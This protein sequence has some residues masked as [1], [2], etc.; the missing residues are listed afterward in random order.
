MNNHKTKY[1]PNLTSTDCVILFD[2][3]CKLCNAWSKFIIRYDKK[4]IFKL[5]SVQS[6]EGQLIL[7]YF[8]FPTDYFETML[9]IEDGAC[10]E[11]SDAFFMIISKLEF[12][13]RMFIIF[14]FFPRLIRDWVYDRIA[15]NRYKLFGKY[16]HCLLATPDHENRFLKK[17][18]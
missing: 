3:V 2:G 4:R 9:Y 14:K 16:D 12:P 10:Y 5:A 7:D 8:K 6:P 17:P 13:W 18:E 15:L 1:P 11:K